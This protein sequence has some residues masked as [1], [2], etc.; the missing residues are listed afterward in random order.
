MPGGDGR[1]LESA[2]EAGAKAAGPAVPLAPTVSITVQMP[3]LE[4]VIGGQ[5]Y[6]VSDTAAKIVEKLHAAE[7]GWVAGTHLPKGRNDKI[8]K[9]MPPEVREAIES[10]HYGYRIKSAYACQ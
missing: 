4:V 5:P 1:E 6:P 2:E 9:K 7:G 10:G 3:R 8:I